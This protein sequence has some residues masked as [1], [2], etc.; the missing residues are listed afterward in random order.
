MSESE[1]IRL[2][3]LKL[4]GKEPYFFG[5]RVE[6]SDVFGVWC[7]SMS[8]NLFFE[9]ED[10]ACK[11]IQDQKKKRKKKMKTVGWFLILC[12]AILFLSFVVAVMSG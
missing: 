1:R 2:L 9:A 11:Q 10:R 7:E 4:F 6:T 8:A 12:A 3:G 5:Q